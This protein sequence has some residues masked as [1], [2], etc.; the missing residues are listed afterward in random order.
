MP[1]GIR[2]RH[3]RSCDAAS[4]CRCSSYEAWVYSRRDDRKIRKTF[5]T[6]AAALRAPTSITL[7]QAAG[8]FLT[9]A[10]DGRIPNRSRQ[11]YK[12]AALRGY[13]HALRERVLPELGSRRLSDITRADVQDLADALTASGLS[14]STVQNTLDPLRVI[15]R[16]AINGILSLS[17]RPSTSSCAARRA[18]ASGSQRPSRL[19]RSWPP[20]PTSSGRCGRRRSTPGCVAESSGRCGGRT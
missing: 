10:R 17:T 16:R 6:L 7:A 14:A 18:G 12:P 11:P 2:L 3:S 1:E 13:E 8:E 20:S 15:F 4:R 5:P 9:G 19:W